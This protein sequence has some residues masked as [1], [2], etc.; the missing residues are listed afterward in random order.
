[1]SHSV[2]FLGPTLKIEEAREHLDA[3]YLPPVSQGDIVSI[4][5]DNPAAIGIIDGYFQLVPSVWHKEVL[6]AIEQGV[7][8]AGAASMGALRAAEL[9]AFGMRGFGR[10]FRWYHSG[11]LE[12]D[13]EVAVTHG[14]IEVGHLPISVA[15]VNIR[16][17]LDRAVRQDGLSLES[18]VQL[19]DACAETPYWKRSFDQMSRDAERLALPQQDRAILGN[20][21]H[22]DQKRLDAIEMLQA[23]AAG[24][25]DAPCPA[26]SFNHTSKCDQLIDRDTC[27]YRVG[28]G[29]LTAQALVDFYLLDGDRT[30]RIAASLAKAR[31][32]AK[33]GKVLTLLEQ[34]G[35]YDAVLAR[36][37]ERDK[38][39]GLRACEGDDKVALDSIRSSIN[40]A[41]TLSLKEIAS[42]I[43]F[44]DPERF[45]ER[46]HRFGAAKTLGWLNAE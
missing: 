29:R 11:F 40:N 18:A 24:L 33:V 28:D 7:T 16:A 9:A 6:I 44:T 37:I 4:L 30:G 3:H 20:A 12:A 27:L 21:Q 31:T 39:S 32:G 23:M 5:K 2:I 42:K 17:T 10:I 34:E 36:A 13:D 46:V 15:M 41:E 14:P 45:L 25:P 43:G 8:I 26:Q 38:S 19:L 35:Q 1:M 22:I